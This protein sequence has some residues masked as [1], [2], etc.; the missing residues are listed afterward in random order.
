MKQIQV[1]NEVIEFP[2]NMS[3]Q[4]IIAVIEQMQQ[5]Q[6]PTGRPYQAITEPLTTMIGSGAGQ[7][8]GGWSG[9][10]EVGKQA[11]SG[12]DMQQAM[13]SGAEAVQGWQDLASRSFMP[14][15]QKGQ[16]GL[17]N[18]IQATEPLAKGFE[19]ASQYSGDIPFERTGSPA[20]GAIG[21]AT[22]TAILEGLGLLGLRRIMPNIRFLDESGMPTQ[23]LLQ[24]LKRM[25]LSWEDLSAAAQAKTPALAGRTPISGQPAPEASLIPVLAEQ[26]K[27]GSEGVLAPLRAAGDRV[28]ADPLAREAARQWDDQGLIQA[29]KTATPATREQMLR[30]LDIRRRIQENKRLAQTTRP[31][32]ITGE[33][34]VK[35]ISHLRD[36]A[37]EARTNLNEIARQNLAGKP[38]QTQPI[39]NVLQDSLRDLNV[40]LIYGPDGVPTPRFEGSQISAN[41]SSQRA[42]KTL[43]RLLSEGGA[44]D[45][46]RFHNL[47][48]QL[49]ELI[50]YRKTSQTGLTASGMN[51]IKQ[52]RSALN[53]QLREVSPE[54][55]QTND[56]L[57][58]I[59]TVFDNLDSISGRRTNIFD[60]DASIKLGQ[61][62][63][64]L[65][66]NY[67]VRGD[68][69]STVQ[70][71]DEISGKYGGKF[72]D[73]L[74]DLAMFANALDT[75]FGS[76]AETSFKGQIEAAAKS[77][78]MADTAMQ[79]GTQGVTAT[80]MDRMVNIYKEMTGVSTEKAYEVME[81]L[82]KRNGQ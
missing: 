52:I 37:S 65:F 53:Q 5:Q 44:P 39:V 26:T 57:S 77:G 71:L 29:V 11:L 8:A 6:M 47:K 80:A 58:D 72:D 46:L 42:I 82:L 59:L 64:K 68:M 62:F 10:Y 61:E 50:D 1:G 14:K 13:K 78:R 7:I 45:A 41:P 4:E 21:Y 27:T 18:V 32:D 35:R 12:A 36:V 17:K 9:L 48:R 79:A 54:Y 67:G 25:G 49:D 2:E 51:I 34:A 3:D 76:V 55:G 31:T 75:R 60:P 22:P 33:S 38:M 23:E 81:Q 56:V 73:S 15:T 28:E 24:E 16:S 74:M 43:I 69:L 66:S 20:M 63:R 30:M 40:E 19:L 70:M